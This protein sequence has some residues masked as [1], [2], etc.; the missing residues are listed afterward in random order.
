MKVESIETFEVSVPLVKPFKTALRTVTTAHAHSIY[1]V[2]ID[3][4]GRKG[5]GEARFF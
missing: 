2:M 5:Y 3:E 1:V 4:E